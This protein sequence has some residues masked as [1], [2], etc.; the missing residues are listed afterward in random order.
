MQNNPDHPHVLLLFIGGSIMSTCL[1]GK[2]VR[3]A[4][5]RKKIM[6]EAMSLVKFFSFLAVFYSPFKP[7][8]KK[9]ETKISLH[10]YRPAMRAQSFII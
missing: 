2:S 10:H 1:P 6:T 5:A 9:P 7:N 8:T 3:R 4:V